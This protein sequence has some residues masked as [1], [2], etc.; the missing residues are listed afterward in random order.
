MKYL[1]EK[2]PKFAFTN[3][4][5][6]TAEISSFT[7][8]KEH[9]FSCCLCCRIAINVSLLLSTP[10]YM[11]LFFSPFLH[12]DFLLLRPFFAL[13]TKSPPPSPLLLNPGLPPSPTHPLIQITLLLYVTIAPAALFL[14]F[15]FY[16]LLRPKLRTFMFLVCLYTS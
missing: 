10:I 5:K 3:L 7:Y 12:Y 14:F 16:S 13:R 2:L 15:S 6:E 9:I 11:M 4:F 1:Q 8:W